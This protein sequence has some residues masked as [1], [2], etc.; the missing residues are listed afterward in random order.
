L[1]ILL[2]FPANIKV[3]LPEVCQFSATRSLHELLISGS[4][5]AKNISEDQTRLVGF[6][7]G[8]R[9][10]VHELLPMRQVATFWWSAVF[11]GEG[12]PPPFPTAD[13]L[14]ALVGDS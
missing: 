3:S 10:P 13:F 4:G 12:S 9:V 1:H 11:P 7:R 14:C 8:C 2:I 5:V 6:I